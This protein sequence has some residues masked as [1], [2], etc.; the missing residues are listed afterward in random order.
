MMRARIIAC[1][2]LTAWLACGP[3]QARL[4]KPTPQQLAGD[5]ATI[6]HNKGDQGRV[7]IGWA[8]SPAFP[9]LVLKQVLDRYIVISIVH[10]VTGPDGS[11][12]WDDIA[13]VQVLDGNNQPLKEVAPDNIPPGLA[14][15]IATSA[16]AMRQN[17]QGKGKISLRVYEP[18]SVNACTAGK[19]LVAYDGE[20]YS[21]DT[22]IPGCEKK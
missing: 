22:P 8:A 1:V 3:S 9:N 12:L 15:F 17:T 13:G 2:F 7:T 5:Y 14:G 10:A 19:L 21:F 16:A 20:T 18:G 6:V 11:T 4:W